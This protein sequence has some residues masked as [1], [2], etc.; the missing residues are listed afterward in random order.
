M[1]AVGDEQLL[2]IGSGEGVGAVI[3]DADGPDVGVGVAGDG[4][5]GRPHNLG[6]LQVLIL[7]GVNDHIGQGHVVGGVVDHNTVTGSQGVGEA[8]VSRTG[9][10]ELDQEGI[11][12]G[13]GV[14]GEVVLIVL[15][16]QLLVIVS[17]IDTLDIEAVL[18]GFDLP[19]AVRSG[20][21]I[22][23][24]H[25]GG[26]AGGQVVAVGGLEGVV[27]ILILADGQRDHL[28]GDDQLVVFHNAVHG[29]Q[30]GAVGL[31]GH[32]LGTAGVVDVDSVAC[33]QLGDHLSQ[34]VVSCGGRGDGLG[35]IGDHRLGHFGFGGLRGD[36]LLR[37]CAGALDP[38][39]DALAGDI[40]GSIGLV[41]SP[42]QTLDV[43]AQ[44]AD[45]VAGIH[46]GQ[47]AVLD[48]VPGS[49]GVSQADAVVGGLNSQVLGA[50]A[51]G[52]TALGG[53]DDPAVGVSAAC[54]GHGVTV[55]GHSG[56][57]RL[58]AGTFRDGG[59]DISV[60]AAGHGDG[61]HVGRLDLIKVDLRPGSA[62]GLSRKHRCGNHT[63][64]HCQNQE[65]RKN[66]GT[67]FLHKFSSLFLLLIRPPRHLQQ[68][69]A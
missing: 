17:A 45:A 56:G 49:S 39:A 37:S 41:A 9:R 58:A 64:H 61:N 30:L 25:I 51:D 48:E 54:G 33:N 55:D 10:E 63:G 19:E 52:V 43:D 62:V 28:V 2:A 20:R 50:I 4:V 35:G 68:E 3:V 14:G 42:V 7:C 65:Q 23:G 36:G 53:G 29:S 34:A 38:E 1:G 26:V 44:V 32:D 15:Q 31:S 12:V 22:E 40:A 11:D 47:I 60:L 69:R 66:A 46:N 57:Q 24:Q 13:V 5:V 59:E 27:A 18:Q 21:S 16:V 6:A 67:Q 8:A